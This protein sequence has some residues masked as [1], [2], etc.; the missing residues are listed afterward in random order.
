[1]T[2]QPQ[3]GIK[4]LQFADIEA[5][6]VAIDEALTIALQVVSLNSFSYENEDIPKTK[7]EMEIHATH[8]PSW[9]FLL[10]K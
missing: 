8:L 3:I 4:G 7:E 9:V 6:L 10:F 5:S 2:L 1:M